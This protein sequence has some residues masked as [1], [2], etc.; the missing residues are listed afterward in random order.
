MR[1]AIWAIFPVNRACCCHRDQ[2]QD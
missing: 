2:F 1:V